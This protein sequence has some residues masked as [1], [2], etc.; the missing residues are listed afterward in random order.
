MRDY[1]CVA[2]EAITEYS[3]IAV[4]IQEAECITNI[5]IQNGQNETLY[6]LKRLMLATYQQ[7]PWR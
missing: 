3:V 6:G 4:L 1:V 7:I 2:H 5:G